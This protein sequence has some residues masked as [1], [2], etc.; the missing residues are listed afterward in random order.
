M[1]VFDKE[2]TMRA[3]LA[4]RQSIRAV[5][6]EAGVSGYT[7][8]KAFLGQPLMSEPTAKIAMA[9]DLEPK[10]IDAPHKRKDTS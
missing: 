4:R 10:W 6:Q 1:F 7:L 2:E 9:L 3:F 5:A 8:Q